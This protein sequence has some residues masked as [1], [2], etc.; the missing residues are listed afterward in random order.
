MKQLR[1][2]VSLFVV[3]TFC[4]VVITG[5]LS[6]VLPYSRTTSTVHSVF[7]FLFFLGAGAHVVNNLRS[8]IS[9]IRH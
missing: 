8:L 1:I 3:T 5:I 9:Y 2:W 7:G 6:F 4:V